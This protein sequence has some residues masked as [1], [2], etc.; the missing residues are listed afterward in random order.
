[1][2]NGKEQLTRTQKLT[3]AACAMAVILVTMDFTAIDVV[4]T[5][6]EK[7][8]DSD[9]STIQ[10]IVNLYF[11]TFAALL[12]AGGRLADMFGRRRILLIGLTIFAA[13]SLLGGIAQT[14]WWLIG[15]RGLQGTGGALLW[16]AAMGI[17]FAVVPPSRKAMAM[18]LI[19]GAAGLGTAV[20]PALGGLFGELVSW[21][22]VLF[23]N[24]PVAA[25]AAAIALRNVADD[26][27]EEGKHRVDYGGIMLAGG[28]LAALLLAIDQSSAWGWGDVRTIGLLVL[29]ALLVVALWLVE[30]RV[31]QPLLPSD[32][33]RNRKF[34]IPALVAGAMASPLFIVMFYL[35]QFFEKLKGWTTL[36]A[37][38]GSLPLTIALAVSA[39]FAGGLYARLG[40]KT[41]V[42]GGALAIGI[43]AL[44][45][46]LVDEATSYAVLVPGL[47]LIGVGLG[48]GLSSVNTTAVGSTP[49][50]RTAV[51]SGLA[52]MTRTM[53]ATIALAIATAVYIGVGENR[54][55]DNLSAADISISAGKQ[56]QLEGS[57]AGTETA[58]AV[59]SEL[60]REEAARV[61]PAVS[62]AF[63]ASL[64]DVMFFAAGLAGLAALVALLFVGGRIEW[65]HRLRRSTVITGGP[66]PN[67]IEH[68]EELAQEPGD[69]S[70]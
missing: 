11:L 32:V 4:I 7:D 9:L 18:G 41:L 70:R 24:L 42:A 50:N 53:M 39:L 55:D 58:Q 68:H 22:L 46:A 3:L 27:G 16:P 52:Y 21:R 67:T 29:S 15:A 69:A 43:G 5:P 61:T 14:D 44:I 10:W 19:I 25:V 8:L 31:D 12:V 38:A 33:I 57:L 66:S 64:H 1:M 48:L 20:G 26:P 17:A 59:I 28:A 13:M 37:G 23:F 34:V 45:V 36:A 47:L 51:A 6:I 35:P 40:P 49:P 2:T 63:L 54:L 62:D 60:P 56:Q 65:P 30:T